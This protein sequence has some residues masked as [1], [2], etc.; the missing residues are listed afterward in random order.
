MRSAAQL[1]SYEVSQGLALI[2]V[3]MM[4]GSLSLTQIVEAQEDALW[5]SS[6]SSSAS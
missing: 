2:G 6:R 1:I 5:Y 4:A 3:V